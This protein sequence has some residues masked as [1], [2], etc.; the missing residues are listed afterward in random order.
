MERLDGNFSASP[1]FANG[2]V[3]FLNETGEATWVQAGKEFAILSKN[4]V[5]GRTFAT[6]AFSNSAMYLRT[7]ESLY[8][9]AE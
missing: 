2:H 5:S 1:V 4:T 3:L 6:P 8:K 7:D 9:F